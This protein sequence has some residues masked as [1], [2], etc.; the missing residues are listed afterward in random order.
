MQQIAAGVGSAAVT[1]VYF[2]HL[3]TSQVSAM[4]VSL[5]VVLGITALCLLAV[6]LL[7][8]KAANLEH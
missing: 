3:E 1:S 8:R 5:G 7:P 2:G 6:P 4:T